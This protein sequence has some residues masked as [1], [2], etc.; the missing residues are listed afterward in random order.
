MKYERLTDTPTLF[1]AGAPIGS[2]PWAE[3]RK[4]EL[5]QAIDSAI[6]GR[7]KFSSEL[8]DF[9]QTHAWELFADKDGESFRTFRAFA[10]A[11]RPYGLGCT[12]D[13]LDALLDAAKKTVQDFAEMYGDEPLKQPEDNEPGPGRGNTKTSLHCKDVLPVSAGNNAVYLTRRIARDR[14]DILERMKAGEFTSVRAAAK[15]AGIVKDKF[16]MPTDPAAAGRYLAQRVDREWLEA[17]IDSYYKEIE[18]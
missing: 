2:R 4:K 9:W 15:E 17:L 5:E 1:G 6:A 7:I 12:E 14:P 3:Y 10:R 16:Q 11:Q 8:V 18:E 13:D